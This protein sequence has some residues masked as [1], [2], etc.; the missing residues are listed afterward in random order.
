MQ[1]ADNQND[2]WT[3]FKEDQITLV[4]AAANTRAQLRA[5]WVGERRCCNP[6]AMVTD[7]TNE[8]RSECPSRALLI[9]ELAGVLLLE[10]LQDVRGRAAGSATESLLHLGAKSL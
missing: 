10:S 7:V 9:R 5:S 8:S 4:D 6:I 2:R 3:W 1:D